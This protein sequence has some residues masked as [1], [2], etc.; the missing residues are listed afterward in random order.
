M[1]YNA[2]YI[3]ENNNE[4]IQAGIKHLNNQ[5]NDFIGLMDNYIVGIFVNKNAQSRGIGKTIIRLC[6]KI[7]VTLSLKVYQKINGLY[8]FIK[9]SN[10]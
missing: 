3:N 10:L 8:L 5:I 2:G 4:I 9:E 7:K 6:Q 1:L